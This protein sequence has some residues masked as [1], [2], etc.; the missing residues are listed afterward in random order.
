MTI[1]YLFFGL[2]I[3]LFN[4]KNKQFFS[5]ERKPYMFP[6]QTLKIKSDWTHVNVVKA[7]VIIK[8]MPIF[9]TNTNNFSINMIV[10]FKFNKNLLSLDLIEKFSFVNTMCTEKKLYYITIDKN[11]L[12]VEYAVRIDFSS[13]LDHKFFPINDHTIFFTL[14]NN[15]F[16]AEDVIFDVSKSDLKFSSDTQITDWE[17]LGGQIESG[18]YLNEES[19]SSQTPIIARPR[20]I[21]SIF[22]KKSGLRKVHLIILPILMIV[23]ISSSLLIETIINSHTTF[24]LSIGALTGILAYRFIIINI[25]PNIGYYSLAEHIYNLCLAIV[26][27]NFILTIIKTN[28]NNTS[29]NYIIGYPWFLGIMGFIIIMLIYFLFYWDPYIKKDSKKYLSTQG[30]KKTF[31]HIKSLRFQQLE[32]QLRTY[33]KY[34]FLLDCLPFFLQERISCKVTKFNLMK[35]LQL[36]LKNLNDASTCTFHHQHRIILLAGLSQK[37]CLCDILNDLIHQHILSSEL[38]LKNK[39]DVLLINE[40]NVFATSFDTELLSV[41]L[42]LKIKNP[43]QVI[44]IQTKNKLE[45]FANHHVRDYLNTNKLWQYSDEFIRLFHQWSK[46]TPELAFVHMSDVK[47]SIGQSSDRYQIHFSHFGLISKLGGSNQLQRQVNE[48]GHTTWILKSDHHF[49]HAYVIIAKH[50]IYFAEGYLHHPFVQTQFQ[51]EYGFDIKNKQQSIQYSKLIIPS[52]MDFSHSVSLITNKFL[53]GIESSFM[54]QN[55]HGGIHAKLMKLCVINDSYNP[56][57]AR[58][59]VLSLIKQ[60]SP[61]VPVLLGPVGTPTLEA[62]ADL[63]QDKK[64]MVLFPYS[65]TQFLRQEQFENIIFFRKSNIDEANLLLD[66]ML[67]HHQ[68]QKIAVVYQDDNYGQPIMAALDNKLNEIQHLRLPYIRNLF[69]TMNFVH[70]INK[71]NPDGILFLSAPG[72]AYKIVQ[73]LE[74]QSIAQIKLFAISFS[75]TGFEE[76]ASPLGI[77]IIQSHVIPSLKSQLPIVK[78]FHAHAHNATFPVSI[79]DEALHGFIIAQIYQEILKQINEPFTPEAIIDYLKNL[80]HF[81]FK[82]LSLHLNDATR[83]LYHEIWIDEDDEE[84]KT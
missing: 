69:H 2:V 33:H 76:K 73:D 28:F 71:F 30:L 11:E 8:N 59:N 20:I 3:Y 77:K 56:V 14:Q 57:L 31:N 19:I 16:S 24:S 5:N 46:Q 81:N 18:L 37:N 10:W 78:K 80:K 67:N 32:K 50:R 27:S 9:D 84:K 55:S 41:F 36:G 64:V 34:S 63:I 42:I 53:Q 35:L 49:Q 4:L 12:Y 83:E 74:I 7:G 60:A 40:L 54:E 29:I 17:L 72:V 65:G 68:L 66:H 39:Y 25:S 52:T 22:I 38:K 47:I 15:A 13:I 79:S 26:F 58:Q 43:K 82:G 45:S 75:A 48:K 1:A 70:K 44:L 21:C 62:Y 6:Y 61:K 23:F 51:L